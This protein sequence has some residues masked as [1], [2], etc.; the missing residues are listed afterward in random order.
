MMPLAALGRWAGVHPP[1]SLRS[2]EP[3][4]SEGGRPALGQLVEGSRGNGDGVSP[5]PDLTRLARRCPASVR[6]GVLAQ[7]RLLLAAPW[8]PC[9]CS[10]S[11]IAEWVSG[12]EP[13]HVCVGR[14]HRGR[15]QGP[16]R[17]NIIFPPHPDTSTSQWRSPVRLS[18]RFL[19]S[20]LLPRGLRGSRV[21]SPSPRSHSRLP[22]VS[23][24]TLC[25][26]PQ[27]SGP[28]VS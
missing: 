19:I 20:P 21:F 4:L 5:S 13:L 16:G 24:R 1:D 15:L 26:R 27:H 12:S 25:P 18:G 11:Q 7:S 14:P 23:Q 2:S 6:C 28:P 3:R 10:P 8:S 17:R 22:A 9:V